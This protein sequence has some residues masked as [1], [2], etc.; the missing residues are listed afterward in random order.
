MN[1][2]LHYLMSCLPGDHVARRY[3]ETIEQVVR[4]ERLG[5]ESVWPV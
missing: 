5:F 3:Q 1:F 4:A 2:G